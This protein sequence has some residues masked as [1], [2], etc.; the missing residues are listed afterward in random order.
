M[1]KKVLIPVDL[2]HES[3]LKDLI[4]AACD[5]SSGDTEV[6]FDFLYVDDSGIHQVGSPFI[7]PERDK[8]RRQ[9][10][11][12]S[13]VKL[14]ASLMPVTLEYDCHVRWGIVHEQVLEEA[15]QFNADIIIMMASKPGLSSYFIGS[16]ADRILRHSQCSVMVLK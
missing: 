1:Y 10:T 11:Q 6:R 12:E 9:E 3:Q 16:N 5:L 2:A 8:L 14:A 13:L 15:K 7:E 4:E